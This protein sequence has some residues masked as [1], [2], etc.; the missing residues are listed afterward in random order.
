MNNAETTAAKAAT[1]TTA[2]TH[3]TVMEPL[4]GDEL[5]RAVI[6]AKCRRL[7]PTEKWVLVAL[8]R[9]TDCNGDCEVPHR[10]LAAHTGFDVSTVGKALKRLIAK[11]Y[12]AC[13]KMAYGAT[14][15]IVNAVK[16]STEPL[17][18]PEEA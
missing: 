13:T 14:S 5:I 7:S 2:Q 17:A 11:G 15:Y 10:F 4:W 9:E 3:K 1:N 12:V 16:L 6:D 18:I 8:C